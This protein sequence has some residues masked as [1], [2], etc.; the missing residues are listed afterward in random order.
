MGNP[1]VLVIPFPAQGHIIPLLELSR[2]LVNHGFKITFV[3]TEYNH[4]RI[5]NAIGVKDKIGDQIHMVTIPDGIETLEDR[6]KP[7]KSSAAVLNVM[8]GK[9][10]ELID[11]ICG[12]NGEEITCVLAD[13][14]IGWALEIAEKKGIRRAAFCPAAAALLVLVFNIPN[15][16]RDGIIADDGPLLASNQL[17]DSVG[18]FWTEDATCLN[19]LD[20]QPP[21]SVIYVAFG[22]FT[23]FDP[24]QFQE[25]ALG[26]E[27]CN[28]PFLWVVR[29]DTTDGTSDAYPKGFHDRVGTRG[30]M[31]G[32]VAQQKILSH[33]SVACF[34]SH[35]GWNSTIEGVSNG[36]PFLCWPYFADQF[37]N[38]NYICDVWKVGL[39]LD[40]DESGIIRRGEI[41][42]KVEQL[43]WDETLKVRALDLKKLVM[44]SIKEGG[45]SDN[46]LKNFI[47]WMKA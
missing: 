16:I 21:H 35:C 30:Q 12:S 1:H 33:P 47:E 11:R 23:I 37:L 13:Q 18:N 17:R 22:S 42:T 40:R 5:M 44:A 41:K 28:R 2:H 9:L 7:G 4:D 31:V 20:R 36:M 43:L 38:Q 14:S 6:K 25:L 39:G 34:L 15:L 26:L 46:N 45:A 8:P 19:W 10:E 24:T 27:L 3:N 32:S 29:P